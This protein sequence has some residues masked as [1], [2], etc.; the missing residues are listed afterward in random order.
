MLERK[1]ISARGPAAT[2]AAAGL[3]LVV[4]CVS[5]L[6]YEPDVKSID[7]MGAEAAKARLIEVLTKARQP[8]ITSVKVTDDSVQYFYDEPTDPFYISTVGN[9]TQIFFVAIDRIEVYSNQNVFVWGAPD[10]VDK[11]LF[12]SPEDAR[13]FADLMM[14][15]RAKVK[16]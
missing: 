2:L 8:H 6:A 4:G 5:Q 7:K 15:Y 11:V 12:W 10:H 3:A 1:T 13:T 16:K 14:S 9:T